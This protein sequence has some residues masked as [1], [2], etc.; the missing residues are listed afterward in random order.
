[1]NQIDTERLRADLHQ[2]VADAERVL[3]SA[4]SATG[5]QL[6]ELRTRAQARLHEAREQ[7][8]RLESEA[9]SRARAAAQRG[10]EYAHSHPWTVAGVAAFTGLLV[11]LLV[12]RR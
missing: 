2:V 10:N 11:G 7:L 6:D 5:G 8:S 1:M 3:K 4:A 12:A 9:A